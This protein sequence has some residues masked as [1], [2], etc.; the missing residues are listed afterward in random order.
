MPTLTD[1][2]NELVEKR[3]ALADSFTKVV[4]E[5]RAAHQ[6]AVGAATRQL[7]RGGATPLSMLA[8]G[9]SWFDYPVT[10]AQVWSFGL[11]ENSILGPN[12]LPALG[13]LKP[14]VLSLALHGQAMTDMLGLPKL[15]MTIADL[16]NPGNWFDGKPDAILVSGGGNDVVG[17]RLALFVD[18]VARKLD[19]AAFSGMLD[20]VVA[21]YQKLFHLRDLHA[22][23]VPIFGH[24]YDYAIPNGRHIYLPDEGP[25]LQPS[26]QAF[27]LSDAESSALVSE[28]IDLFH[29]RLAS[30]AAVGA[31]RFTLVDTRKSVAPNTMPT[32]GWGNEMHPYADGFKSVARRFLAALR[33]AFPGRI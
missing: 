10:D 1:A 4:A 24:C 20:F 7:A 33:L 32:L 25:W 26:L 29:D 15:Q 30:L 12:H 27:G 14:Q 16:E 3:R 8:I 31:N 2:H 19:E 6:T 22:P 18:P 17:D 13:A 5:R 9:D 21:A 11:A 23:G 28:I